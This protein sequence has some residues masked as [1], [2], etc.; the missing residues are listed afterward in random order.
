M[1]RILI[2]DDDQGICRIVT[3]LIEDMEHEAVEAATL[4]QGL[5]LSMEGGIDLVLLDLQ[6]PQGNG[7]DI[8]PSV[9]QSPSRPEVIIITGSGVQAAELAFKCGAWDYVQKPFHLDEIKLPI[10][11][12][13][14]YRQEKQSSCSPVSLKRT[15]IIGNSPALCQC[16]EGVARAAVSDASVLITG[17]TGTGKELFARAIHE[18][19]RR[20]Q[21]NFIIV[22]CGSLPETLMESIL[23][24]HEKGAF[25]GADRRR[26]GL[27]EQAQ[28]GTL[29]LDELGDLPYTMQKSLLRAIQEKRVRP[30][31]AAV[32]TPVDFRVVAATNRD[33]EK[34]V[35]EGAFREDLLYRV[36]A[37]E[38]KL[39]PLR[40][41]R[42]DIQEIAIRKT[43]RLCQQYGM[44]IKGISQEFLDVLN[45]QDWPGNIR[46]LI[47]V[48][49]YS[50][51]AA[52]LD[53][54]LIPKHIPYQYRTAS[55]KSDQA[56]TDREGPGSGLCDEAPLGTLSQYRASH[57]ETIEKKYLNALLEQA[58]GDRDEACRVSGLSQSQLYALLKKHGLP[59]FRA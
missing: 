53:P 9:L 56:H 29:F 13:L 28:G 4:E 49:E 26:E 45:A 2:I 30:L 15:D 42:E 10:S 46:E 51:A 8:L 40:E 37:M 38:I 52:G 34:L 57:W 41:R 16:L 14:Q 12:A 18:N 22:D 24:G 3:R 17:E 1:A 50:L 23:F 31:G 35:S 33:L 59:R 58:G 48:L 5:E 44:E 55:L 20:S 43:Q 39:P 54:T 7:L 11:R 32:E 47:N 25:T 27:L 19:S 21:G 36:R 6:F